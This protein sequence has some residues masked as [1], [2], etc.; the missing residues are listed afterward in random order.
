MN[1]FRSMEGSGQ[2]RNIVVRAL[3]LI[4][5]EQMDSMLSET[6]GLTDAEIEIF[7]MLFERGKKRAMPELSATTKA[8]A[9]GYQLSAIFAKT[10][11]KFTS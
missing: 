6:F 10:E 8:H 11:V 3:K 1:F 7:P 5:I 9:T 2:G 4:W